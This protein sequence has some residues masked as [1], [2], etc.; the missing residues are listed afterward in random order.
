LT[1]APSGR[2]MVEKTFT[3]MTTLSRECRKALTD[4]FGKEHKGIPFDAVEATMRKEIE[5]W[6]AGRDRNITV[7]HEASNR[8]RPGEI[9]LSYSGVTK[10]AHFKFHVDGQ[11]ALAGSEANSPSYL[12]N[13]NVYVDKRDFSK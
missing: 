8:G 5:S 13:I 4:S 12:K 3:Y 10:D 11:F 1:D 9:S 7:K 2:E 6:F